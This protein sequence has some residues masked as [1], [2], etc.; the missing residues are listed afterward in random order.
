MVRCGEPGVIV[1]DVDELVGCTTLAGE[2][3]FGDT[4]LAAIEGLERL[5]VIEGTLNLFRNPNLVDLG[6]P[7]LQL[8]GGELLVHHNELL[9]RADLPS[10]RE[11]GALLVTTNAAMSE[12][13][14]DGLAT[15]H[16]LDGPSRGP[17][18]ISR[19]RLV[20]NSAKLVAGALPPR[21]S[22]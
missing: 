7:A 21:S 19:S 15:V 1:E 17:K 2:L 18:R 11:V 12:V 4:Q 6:L 13:G 20:A 8:V 16:V 22:Q 10:L 9:E 14:L 3:R 5:R